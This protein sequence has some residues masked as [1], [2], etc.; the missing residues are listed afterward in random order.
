[1]NEYL[2]FIQCSRHKFDSC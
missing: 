1:M 2:R